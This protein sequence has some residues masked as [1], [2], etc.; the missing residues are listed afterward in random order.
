MTPEQEKNTEPIVRQPPETGGTPALLEDFVR[1]LRTSFNTSSLYPPEHPSFKKSAGELRDKINEML[2]AG[3]NITIGVMPDRLVIAGREFAGAASYG[4]LAVALH[5]RKIKSVSFFPGI[6]AEDIAF[7]LSAVT[8]SVKEIAGHGGIN[9]ILNRYSLQS[10]SVEELDYQELLEGGTEE[11]TQVWQ[12]LLDEA[13]AKND[14]QAVRNLVKHLVNDFKG[15]ARRMGM[16]QFLDDEEASQS[17]NRFLDYLAN[18]DREGFRECVS[19]IAET[20]LTARSAELS[21]AHVA[22]LRKFFRNCSDGDFAAI[23]NGELVKKDDFDLLGLDL[24]SRLAEGRDHAN[25][26]ALTLD[27]LRKEPFSSGDKIGRRIE[28]LFSGETSAPD[29]PGSYRTS[30]M[31]FLQNASFGQERML[32]RDILEGNYFY[33]LLNL[34][35]QENDPARAAKIGRQMESGWG[36]IVASADIGYL[37]SLVELL[38]QRRNGPQALPKEVTELL[39]RLVVS[40]VEELIWDP[41]FHDMPLLEK[42]SGSRK[43]PDFYLQK[44]FEEGLVTSCALNLFIR[45]FP[46]ELDGFYSRLR[47]MSEDINFLDHMVS[48]LGGTG[49]PQIERI[50]ESIYEFSGVFVRTRVLEVMGTDAVPG[51]DF[52]LRVLREADDVSL[53]REALKMIVKQGSG[54]AEAAGILFGI[55]SHWG[56]KNK[57]LMVNITAAQ[58]ASF[59]A[60]VPS[61]ELLN[62]RPFFWNAALRRKAGEALRYLR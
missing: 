49:A 54:E 58:E 24:F 37:H 32:D 38:E 2:S 48:A 30:L 33:M 10:I 52:L 34:L 12:F 6:T 18:N 59:R 31:L 35:M 26:A 51:K 17:V 9:A 42:V 45:F 57:L 46:E 3:I 60:A 1:V 28:T 11:V 44:F 20:A 62:K 21:P 39:D 61:L 25:I 27:S 13:V 53:K 29:L 7:F 15:V 14:K 43:G 5:Q 16:S 55:P 8:F 56:K 19:G 23:L 40:F 36:K 47:S 4:E 41:D 50:L 22:K